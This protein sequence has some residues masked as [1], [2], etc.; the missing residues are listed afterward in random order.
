MA[1]LPD[2]QHRVYDQHAVVLLWAESNVHKF[3]GVLTPEPLIDHESIV[4]SCMTP[5]HRKS[6]SHSFSCRSCF[7]LRLPSRE[8]RSQTD[9]SF[10]YALTE[11][12]PV[13]ELFL[14]RIA[15]A[16][17]KEFWPDAR[18]LLSDHV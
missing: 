14:E 1:R 3:Q 4:P 8:S 2:S 16:N 12:L 9:I 17:N 7:F 11:A 5:R 6:F 18:N 15:N 13:P 10:V